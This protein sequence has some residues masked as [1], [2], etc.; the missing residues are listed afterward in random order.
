MKTLFNY[1]NR[2]LLIVIILTVFSLHIS[3]Q[4]QKGGTDT[5]EKGLIFSL[6]FGCPL[7][8]VIF[9]RTLLLFEKFFYS[10]L[11][12]SIAIILSFILTGEL[13]E[14]IYGA[15]YEMYL[16]VFTANLLFFFIANFIGIG[17][18]YV[19]LNDKGEFRSLSI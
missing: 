18:L 12:S 10:F 6:V 8:Y 15:D 5:F 2:L 9:S 19:L 11:S 17:L 14:L 16:N 1:W 7:F 4:F 3:S 13:L